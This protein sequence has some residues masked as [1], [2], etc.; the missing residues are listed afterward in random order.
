VQGNPP[1]GYFAFLQFSC[2]GG[3]GWDK[4]GGSLEEKQGS[5]FFPALSLFTLGLRDLQGRERVFFFRDGL[6]MTR[7]YA[8]SLFFF[9]PLASAL[10]G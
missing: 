2:A 6:P 9:Q 3:G 10:K 1:R 4:G 7:R 8:Q 5:L